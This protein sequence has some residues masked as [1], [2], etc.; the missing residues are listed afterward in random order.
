M[1]KST[2]KTLW[3]MLCS[4]KLGKNVYI[5]G[6]FNGCSKPEDSDEFLKFFIEE[7][8]NFVNNGITI[9]KTHYDVIIDGIICDAPAKAYILGVKCHSGYSSCTKCE[10]VGQ[11]KK[12]VC[13][14]GGISTLREDAKFNE[15]AYSDE[16]KKKIIKKKSSLSKIPKLGLVSQVPL[17]PMHLV[18]LGVCRKLFLIWLFARLSC[19]LPAYVINRISAAMITLA[20]YIPYEFA[21]KPRSF[22]DIKFFKATEW[23]QILLYIGIIV[24]KDNVSP[25]IYNHFVVLHVAISIFSNPLMCKYNSWI[26]YGE[27]LLCMFVPTFQKLY[28][29]R[30]VSHNVHG[31]YHLANDVRR[32]G[33]LD[34][35]SAFRFENF[36]G[37][38]KNLIHNGN[39]PLQQISRRLTEIENRKSKEFY[40]CNDNIPIFKQQHHTGPVADQPTDVLQYK[41]GIFDT[42]KINCDDDKNSYV[43]VNHQHIVKVLNIVCNNKDYCIVGKKL[44][45]LGPVYTQPLSSSQLGINVVQKNDSASPECWKIDDITTKVL[46][47]PYKQV[48]VVFPILHTLRN[49]KE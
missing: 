1:G 26:D 20:D 30:Y 35:F 16:D 23:R 14:P 38:I 22:K 24:L 12:C 43:Y 42:F 40:M 49:K 3:P 6:I 32:Y 47:L 8:K 28:G 44:D 41:V 2:A 39:R 18:F 10:I 36:I 46:I 37:R 11:M 17:D 34:T 15:F 21:R 29:R 33:E 4:D 9:L 31:L 25:A 48:K 19:K 27:K 5:V 7:A 45:I 13:F